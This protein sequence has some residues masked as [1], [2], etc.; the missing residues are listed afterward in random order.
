[1]ITAMAVPLDAA[2]T[3]L[4]GGDGGTMNRCGISLTVRNDSFQTIKV[5][6]SDFLSNGDP[7][8]A[9]V[10]F[11]NSRGEPKIIQPAVVN[12]HDLDGDSSE[13]TEIVTVTLPPGKSFAFTCFVRL[14]EFVRTDSQSGFMTSVKVTA[15]QGDRVILTRTKD[16]NI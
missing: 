14:R 3:D 7:F 9:Q 11:M 16:I 1:M 4:N 12:V 13:D 8:E 5:R 10:S 15:F 2:A 6:L